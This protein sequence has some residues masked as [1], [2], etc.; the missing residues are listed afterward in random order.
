MPFKWNAKQVEPV[1]SFTPLAPSGNKSY[2]IH[3]SDDRESHRESYSSSS[4]RNKSAR[5]SNYEESGSSSKTDY[6]RS[7]N[8]ER[9]SGSRS[10]RDRPS[11]SRREDRDRRDD[12][13]DNYSRGSSSRREDRR[14]R[15]RDERGS[16]KEHRPS[17]RSNVA[18]GYQPR[19]SGQK[20]DYATSSSTKSNNNRDTSSTKKRAAY[21]PRNVCVDNSMNIGKVHERYRS[22][23]VVPMNFLNVEIPGF[24]IFEKIS[25]LNQV[26]PDCEVTSFVPRTNSQFNKYAMPKPEPK[27]EKKEDEN[28][29]KEE[30]QQENDLE[31]VEVKNPY[32]D[33]VDKSVIVSV[34]LFLGPGYEKLLAN[35]GLF[36][37]K[38]KSRISRFN[39][40]TLKELKVLVEVDKGNY[41]LP[42]GYYNPKLDG[43]D[44]GSQETLINTGCGW[45]FFDFFRGKN[46]L[47]SN[48]KSIISFY[49]FFFK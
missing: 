47:F 19:D 24:K 16:S 33:S 10:E 11:S 7:S 49:R 1:K 3:R 35:S 32:S 36:D 12:K 45:W 18:T 42:G 13:R 25:F 21:I 38:T 29:M 9:E 2:P 14:E 20:R 5:N 44:V 34:L 43:E 15:D 26:S 17:Y 40:T 46:S 28:E 30:K 23:M 39:K 31:I 48:I 6:Y 27:E 8:R 4:S 41:F 22:H 37:P